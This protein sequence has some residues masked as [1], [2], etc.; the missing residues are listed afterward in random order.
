[1]PN[2]N[3]NQGDGNKPIPAHYQSRF[4][5]EMFSVSMTETESGIVARVRFDT[6]HEGPPGHAHGGSIATVLDETMGTLAFIH[7]HKVLAARLEVKY[8]KPV[9]LNE[10]LLAVCTITSRNRRK[11]TAHAELK[12]ASGLVLVESSGL[13]IDIEGRFDTLAN[14]I[15]RA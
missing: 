6:R 14:E 1:M 3:P 9:P 2:S 10:P 11:I 7:G 13:F 5:R 4:L 15:S 8:R 12:R